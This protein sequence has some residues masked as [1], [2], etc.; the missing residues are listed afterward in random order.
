[1]ESKKGDKSTERRTSS[2]LAER[3]RLEKLR[4]RKA[5]KGCHEVGDLSNGPLVVLFNGEE[6]IVA[7]PKR[8]KSRLWILTTYGF[9]TR[10]MR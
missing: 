5:D 3:A 9:R 4:I 10:C 6:A 1:M 2:R 8:E 7:P